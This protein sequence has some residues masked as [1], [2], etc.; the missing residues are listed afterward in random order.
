MVASEI[1]AS[2]LMDSGEEIPKLKFN[3]SRHREEICKLL[4]WQKANYDS[5]FKDDKYFAS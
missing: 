1:E 4:Q 5:W 2:N 3:M